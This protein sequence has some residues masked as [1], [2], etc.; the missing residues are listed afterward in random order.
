MDFWVRLTSF[1]RIALQNLIDTQ[2]YVNSAFRKVDFAFI[3]AYWGSNPYAISRKFLQEKGEEVIYA[4]GETPLFTM[5]KIVKKAAV[6]EKDI[7]FE[8]GCGRGR[9]CF[10]LALE[11]KAKVVGIDYV[12][13]FIE[14]AKKIASLSNLTFLKEDF[15]HSNLAEA[16]VIYLTGTCMEDR[17]LFILNK[18]LIKL[19][20]GLKLIT[21]S[22]P[23]SDYDEKGCWKMIESFPAAFSFGVADVYIQELSVHL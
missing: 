5:H 10:W 16:T 1:F 12:P 20:P 11:L 2:F 7:V 13:E 8:L 22:F 19:A 3:R 14:K 6:T 4:Y 9:T 23:M 15:L 21:V 18:K 17:D